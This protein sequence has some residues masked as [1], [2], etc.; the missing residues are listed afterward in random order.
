MRK[1][2]FSEAVLL[3]TFGIQLASGDRGAQLE[4]HALRSAAHQR[5]GDPQ[6]AIQDAI[7]CLELNEKHPKG[8]EVYG[9]AVFGMGEYAMAITMYQKA[10]AL[11]F[12][13][14][15]AEKEAAA[16]VHNLIRKVGF[17]VH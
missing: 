10:Q 4:L 7:A 2:Q 6:S 9:D 3:T 11:K 14:R 17:P 13:T 12:S 8:Y 5:G 15:V 16:H 1:D